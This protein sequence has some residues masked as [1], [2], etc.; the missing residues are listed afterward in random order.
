MKAWAVGVGNAD[1]F[2]RASREALKFISKLS[3]LVG[4][5]PY[6]PRGT[7][8]LFDSENSAKIA[9]NEMNAVGIVTGD[10]ICEVEIDDKHAKRSKK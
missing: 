4:V 6:Y 2:N 1:P 5:H 8:I 10:Y 3:G 9:R 7:L